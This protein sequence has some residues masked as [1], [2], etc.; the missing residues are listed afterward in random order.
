M[1]DADYDD[2]EAYDGYAPQGDAGPLAGGRWQ[3]LVNSAGALTSVALMAGVG[4]WAYKLAVRDVRGVP[5]IQALEGPARIAP[6][7]P[8]GE[9]AL[10]QGMAVNAIAAEGTAAAPAD[11]LTLAPQPAGLSDDDAAMGRLAGVAE[12]SGLETPKPVLPPPGDEALTPAAMRP[13]EP[14]PDGPAEPINLEDGAAAAVPFVA[15]DVIAAS[16]PGV[17]RSLKPIPRPAGGAGAADDIDAMAEA[18][19]AAVA[20]AFASEGSEDLDPA[21]LAPGTRLVQIGAYPNQAEA[22]LEWDKTIARFGALMQGK[23]RVIEKSESGGTVFF[24]LRVEGFTD[25]EDARAFC[26]ALTSENAVCVPAV[27]K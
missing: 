9:L 7:E 23:R 25:A 19:A 26:A 16:I 11:R 10:H 12:P 24:R 22:R 3:K 1:A 17:S 18:A 13:T 2:Y 20:A 4:V 8:G 27:V 21:T 14:L 5:V 15:P 6:E